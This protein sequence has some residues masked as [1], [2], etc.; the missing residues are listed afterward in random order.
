[1]EIKK[2]LTKVNF[3]K[4]NNRKIEYIVIHYTGNNGDTSY[5]NAMYFKDI[6]RN[7]SAHYFVDENEI[8]QVVI[9]KCYTPATLGLYTRAQQF[10]Q[11]CS[12]NLTSI[13]QRVSYP[14][15]SKLQ[16]DNE[17]LRRGYQKIIKGSTLL[18]ITLH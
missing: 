12:Q 4:G 11:I 2:L 5:N 9:G 15:L 16:D 6:N 7:A 8:Y 17:R 18:K 1:M 14:T 10:A 13:V 3:N